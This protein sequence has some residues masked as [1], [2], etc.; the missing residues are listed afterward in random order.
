MGFT[1]RDASRFASPYN[2]LSGLK[3]SVTFPL[4]PLE[5]CSLCQATLPPP[6]G[7][8]LS[9]SSISV[10]RRPMFCSF[11][12]LIKIKILLPRE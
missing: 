8:F 3:L 12:H 4:P 10:L 11:L 2:M 1:S 9:L 6:T 5:R 7:S